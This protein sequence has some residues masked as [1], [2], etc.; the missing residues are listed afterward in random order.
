MIGILYSLY[1]TVRIR[2]EK[3]PRDHYLTLM[4]KCSLIAKKNIAEKIHIA[5]RVNAKI[6]IL[7]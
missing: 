4:L 2:W 3:N 1:S 5:H 6:S 7:L